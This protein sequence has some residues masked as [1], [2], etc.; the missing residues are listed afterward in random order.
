M[1][2]PAATF[3]IR[4]VMSSSATSIRVGP[5]RKRADRSTPRRGAARGSR[6]RRPRCHPSRSA[7]TG[8]GGT[9]NR[10]VARVGRSPGCTVR[11]FLGAGRCRRPAP[12]R[13]EYNRVCALLG[14]AELDRRFDFAAPALGLSRQDVHPVFEAVDVEPSGRIAHA[15]RCPR[16]R[17]RAEA[18]R[19]HADA[20]HRG[21]VS[22]AP[23][24]LRLSR[25]ARGAAPG[26]PMV[27]R[28]VA[29]AM[30]S[31]ARS[32]SA[33]RCRPS[34]RPRSDPGRRTRGPPWLGLVCSPRA[35]S[36]TGWDRPT[37]RPRCPRAALLRAR[38]R[39]RP[40]RGYSRP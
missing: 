26:P 27:R 34:S 18:Q 31:R 22:R 23:R 19:E 32:R 36:Q 12:Q 35:R 16:M 4:P 24:D 14:D 1:S 33:R 29:S 7:R 15:R 9:A 10:P 13:D 11:R 38:G 3:Q 2:K 30:R 8:S 20:G 5:S 6:R 28:S 21:P 39:Y 40:V 25:S 37:R 17:H